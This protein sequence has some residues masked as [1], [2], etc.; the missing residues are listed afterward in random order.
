MSAYYSKKEERILAKRIK[1]DPIID[2]TSEVQED[3]D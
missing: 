3:K 2:P 1:L